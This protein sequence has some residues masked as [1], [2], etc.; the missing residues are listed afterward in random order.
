VTWCDEYARSS[1]DARYSIVGKAL[2]SIDRWRKEHEEAG[3]VPRVLI[4][5]IELALQVALPAIVTE[6]DA[7]SA[8]LAAQTFREQIERQLVGPAAWR[9][10]PR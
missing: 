7:D 6:S 9:D 8:A 3:G 5:E 4:Q 10:D 2:D 1:G